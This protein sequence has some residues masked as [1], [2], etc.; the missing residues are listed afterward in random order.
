MPD[1]YF[2]DYIRPELLAL[3]P[4]LYI[5]GT[6]LKKSTFRDENIPVFLGCVSIGLASLYVLASF[7]LNGIREWMTAIFTAITQGV[8]CAGAAVFTNQVL[9]Q[10]S[11]L[12]ECM[13][14]TESRDGEKEQN[15]A[16]P[17]APQKRRMKK[18]N[19]GNDVM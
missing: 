5:I 18:R 10:S 16:V 17:A 3:V 1:K 2:T 12:K 15:T 8:L 7:S 14:K 13:C 19:G 11:K 9:K 6:W 4:V